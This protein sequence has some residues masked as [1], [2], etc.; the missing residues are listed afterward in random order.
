MYTGRVFG[1]SVALLFSI[2]EYEREHWSKCP[3]I[4]HE[5]A[6]NGR[7]AGETGYE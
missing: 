1:L 5:H 2:A 3:I 6:L 7:L 4:E